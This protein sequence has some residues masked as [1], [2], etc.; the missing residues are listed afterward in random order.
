MNIANLLTGLRM[1]LVP[2][3]IVALFVGDGHQTV[4]RVVAFAVFVVAVAAAGSMP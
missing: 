3:F 1:V 2:V 4:A